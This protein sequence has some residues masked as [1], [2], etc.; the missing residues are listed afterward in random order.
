MGISQL[1]ILFG[2]LEAELAKHAELT[3]P[4]QHHHSNNLGDWDAAT[5]FGGRRP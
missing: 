2:P 3:I 1:T 5:F 4:Y